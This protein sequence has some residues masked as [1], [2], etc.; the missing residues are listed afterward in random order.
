MP[1]DALFTAAGDGKLSTRDDVLAQAKRM[2]DDPRSARMLARFTDEWLRLE[3]T[4]TLEKQA[5]VYTTFKPELRTAMHQEVQ[6]VLDEVIWKGDGKLETLLTLPFTFVNAPL[7]GFYGISGVSGDAFTK[8]PLDSK[9][10]G[11]LLTNGGL[12]AVLGVN[13][14]GLTSLVYRGLFVRERLLC[15][16]VADPPPN[17]QGMQPPFDEKTTTARQWS[18]DRQKIQLCG[19]CHSQ[20]DPIG[21]GF[22]NYDGVGLYRTTDRGVPVNARGELTDTDVDGTFNGAI[23]L[24]QKLA[25]STTVRDCLATQLFRYGYGREETPRDTCALDALKASARTTGGNFKD[26]LLALTQTDTFLL[27]SKGEQP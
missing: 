18:E 2:L 24:G 5:E 19:A 9:Q 1:D 7:A 27:R 3:E 13:D 4:E 17:A 23:E 15:Q 10:R 16:P 14:G 20:M 12:M 6:R 26:L 25:K 21:L 22:E 11:G 8:V